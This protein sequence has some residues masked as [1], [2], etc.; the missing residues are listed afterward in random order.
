MV[1]A[2]LKMILFE[3]P[4][5][6]MKKHALKLLDEHQ[7]PTCM[8]ETPQTFRKIRMYHLKVHNVIM[9]MNTAQFLKQELQYKDI[10]WITQSIDSHKA[11]TQDCMKIQGP[12][13]I[14]QTVYSN[15]Y[16]K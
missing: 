3:F 5:I 8:S 11:L 16:L 9:N 12:V 6:N 4:Q 2:C 15:S 1:G 14:P 13:I 10:R 7:I